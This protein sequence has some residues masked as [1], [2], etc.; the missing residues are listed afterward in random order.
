LLLIRIV[1]KLLGANPLAGFSNFIYGVTNV[2]MAPFRN[3]LPTVGTGQS[4]LEPSALI[5]IIVYALIG[6]VI[7]R[8]LTILYSRN[9]TVARS[10]RSG[11]MR[12]RGY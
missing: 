12:P 1:L 2:F 9:V 4:Q 10:S 11:G 5:A 8:I 3:L 6:W 7:A